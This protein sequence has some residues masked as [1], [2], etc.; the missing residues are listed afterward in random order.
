[1]MKIKVAFLVVGLNTG[2]IENYILRFLIHYKDFIEATIYCKSGKSGEME[3]EY[4]QHDITI[5]KMKL[6]Y[7]DLF[8][9][10]NFK[11]ELENENFVAIVDFTGNFA[12]LSLW[13]A[14]KIGLKKRIVWYRNADDKFK[15]T[16]L[17]MAYNKLMN[18]LTYRNATNIL[19]NSKAALNYFYKDYDW[20]L[21]KRFEV[22]YNGINTSQF[23]ESK[24]NL[25]KEFNIPD[26]AFVVGNIGR[27]NE[28]KNHKTAIEVA[29]NLCKLY[30]DIFFIFC[31]KG[32]DVE[33]KNKIKENGL[34]NKILLVGMRRDIINVLN[35]LDC[36][37]M[38][39][40]LEGQPNALI[41]AMIV[42][43]PFVAS[44]IEPIKETVPKDLHKYLIP[45]LDIKK[46][47]NAIIEVKNNLNYRDKFIIADWAKLHFDSSVQFKIF[48]DKFF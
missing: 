6:G 21:D 42:G 33:Y 10:L 4:L 20:Q 25:R 36:F 15:K 1:M 13:I 31:G 17:R 22:V 16:K 14:K 39:S 43:V 29:I 46:A 28:Q 32:V 47:E 8:Q 23:V 37:Y 48:F 7:F 27:L 41:E 19:S 5:K 12:G 38:P 34:E 24:E 40:I 18:V 3:N 30:E 11:K 35:T 45:A 26:S 2:G 44:D 9:Y